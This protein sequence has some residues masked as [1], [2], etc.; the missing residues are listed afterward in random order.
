LAWLSEQGAPGIIVHGVSMG[1]FLAALVAGIDDRV[2]RVVA[3]MP[4]VD[5]GGVGNRSAGH[6]RQLL[7]EHGLA[8][9]RAQ[10]V[11]RVISP[12]AFPCR[13]DYRT[14]YIYAG[15]GDRFTTAGQACQLWKHWEEPTVLWFSGSHVADWA[16]KKNAFLE[17]AIGSAHADRSSS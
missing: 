13:V 4:L 3:G 12:L 7:D 11:H 16:G 2:D 14:R 9:Q 8:G 15:V 1:G 6:V 10:L 5:I 17:R